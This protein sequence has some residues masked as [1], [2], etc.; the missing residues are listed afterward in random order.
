MAITGTE[1]IDRVER[2][3]VRLDHRRQP[4]RGTGTLCGVVTVEVAA[5]ALPTYHDGVLI[6]I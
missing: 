4:A 5:T 3:A 2:D 6:V 1:I